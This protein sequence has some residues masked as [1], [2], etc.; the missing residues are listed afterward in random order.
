[1]RQHTPI[2]WWLSEESDGTSSGK[3][4]GQSLPVI[5]ARGGRIA[6]LYAC[7]NPRLAL[8][9]ESLP[10]VGNVRGSEGWMLGREI[11]FANAHLLVSAPEMLAALRAR[12]EFTKHASTMRIDLRAL[13]LAEIERME[14]D[15]IAHAEGSE[16]PPPSRGRK[17]P[18]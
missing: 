3:E 9:N 12:A 7:A 18:R 8:L 1:M 15:A 17:A 2:G 16:A 11:A 14:A 6:T 5:V 13:R 4:T 10:D